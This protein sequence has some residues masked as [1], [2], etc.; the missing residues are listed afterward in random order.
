MAQPPHN[1]PKPDSDDLIH[2]VEED[3]A[4]QLVWS[5]SA[6]ISR[7]VAYVRGLI[8]RLSVRRAEGNKSSSPLAQRLPQTEDCVSGS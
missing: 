3:P 4:S 5:L 7:S 8:I 6:V 1:W 2:E